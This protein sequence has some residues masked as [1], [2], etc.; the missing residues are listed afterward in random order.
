[1]PAQLLGAHITAKGGLHNSIRTGHAM[2]CTAIQVFTASPQMWRAKEVTEAMAA[3]FKKAQTETG[4][5]D[6]VSH[7]NYLINLCAPEP[8]M[9]RK[10]IDALKGEIG[11]CTLYGIRGVVSHLG[12]HKGAGEIAGLIGIEEA[13]REILDTTPEEV[14]ILMETTAGQ[15]TALMHRFEHFAILLENLK[16][17]PRLGVCMD[18]CHIFVA[19]YDIRT[20]ETYAETMERFGALVGFDRLKAIHCNDSKKGLGSHVDRH[21]HIGIGEIGADG[22]AELVNDPRL[23]RVPIV[24]ETDSEDGGH[25][26]DLATLRSLIRDGVNQ[27]PA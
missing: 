27:R 3:D 11:R 18:T 10:S 25:E 7:E 15:G 8:D 21:E 12:S 16:G 20:P 4:L 6:V 2:G 19:G 24:L 26:R 13:L 1:M 14:S 9:R 23:E 17:H 22:F 5:T